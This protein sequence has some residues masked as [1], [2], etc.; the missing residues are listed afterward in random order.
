MER[1][2]ANT[3]IFNDS[4][5]RS[6]CPDIFF[7]K[8]FVEGGNCVKCPKFRRNSS[9]MAMYIEE[10]PID[11]KPRSRILRQRKTKRD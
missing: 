6:P 1:K 11:F 3:K 8:F 7:D 4:G 2:C 10:T 9:N 5:G